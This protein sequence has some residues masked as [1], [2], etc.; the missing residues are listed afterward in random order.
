M[1]NKPMQ[2]M[3]ET[4]EINLPKSIWAQ[5]DKIAGNEGVS[6]G[7]FAAGAI[8]SYVEIFDDDELKRDDT[9]RFEEPVYAI[10]DQARAIM[11]NKKLAWEIVRNWLTQHNKVLINP[12]EWLLFPKQKPTGKRLT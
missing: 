2:N 6:P 7:E 3:D 8:R 5:L 11:E 4:R 9:K 12:D 1:N 10:E